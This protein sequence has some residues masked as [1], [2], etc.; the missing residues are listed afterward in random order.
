MDARFWPWIIIHIDAPYVSRR[1]VQ[2]FL[3][4]SRKNTIA[5]HMCYRG[6][7]LMDPNFENRRVLEAMECIGPH[8]SRC[9]Q[10]TLRGLYRS[11]TVLASRFFNGVSASQM[12]SLD[13]TSAITDSDRPFCV[14]SFYCAQLSHVEL[15][16]RSLAD[17]VLVND[18]CKHWRTHPLSLTAT[19]YRPSPVILPLSSRIFGY[20]LLVAQDR[21]KTNL[22]VDDVEFDDTDSSSARASHT[23][24]QAFMNNGSD[25]LG[26]EPW[27]W[28]SH[29]EGPSISRLLDY[30]IP[31][32]RSNILLYMNNNDFGSFPVRRRLGSS[33]R[34]L[35]R[36]IGDHTGLSAVLSKWDGSYLSIDGCA[37]F[38]D[39][40]LGLLTQNMDLCANLTEVTIGDCPCT[41]RAL[42]KFCNAR[43][44]SGR[45]L[46]SLDILDGVVL[47]SQAEFNAIERRV[48][49]LRW[50]E[51]EGA[52]QGSGAD[53]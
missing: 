43:K 42:I 44:R 17:F 10:F 53:I 21:T 36:N 35:L 30:A 7:P 3:A 20:A 8:L 31:G 12:I 32:L 13:L 25:E 49:I 28:F 46:D 16:A 5:I 1:V 18:G 37:A 4:A 29:M 24:S 40:F 52:L 50:F 45:Q 47:P 38:D 11:S 19:R 33:C 23:M 22:C 14:T 41:P 51:A 26:D 39:T 34:L 6:A 15:D 48:D 27:I 2:T 9:S